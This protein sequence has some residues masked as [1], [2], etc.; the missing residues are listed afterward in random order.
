MQSKACSNNKPRYHLSVLLVYFVV[1]RGFENTR[2]QASDAYLVSTVGETRKQQPKQSNPKLT[3]TS[4]HT[5][6][7]THTHTHTHTPSARRVDGHHRRRTRPQI[8]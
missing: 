8:R 7:R 1:F 4:S 5:H 3:H 2:T 6:T